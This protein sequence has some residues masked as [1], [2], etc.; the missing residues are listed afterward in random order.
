MPAR[1]PTTRR[2]ASRGRPPL[3]GVQLGF[4]GGGEGV[5]APVVVGDRLYLQSESYDLLCLRKS[6]GKLLWMRTNSY[7]DALS[8]AEKADAFKDVQPLAAKLDGLNA[9]IVA[10]TATPKQLEEKLATEREIHKEIAPTSHPRSTSG[11]T[12]P[13]WASRVTHPSPTAGSSTSGSAWAS[14]PATT[15]TAPAAGSAPTS[16]PPSST[17]SPPRPSSSTARSSSSW[18]DLIAFDAATGQLAW[19]T[20]LMPHTGFNP[21]AS[22]TAPRSPPASAARASSCSATAASCGRATARWSPR[23][24]TSATRASPRPSSR[25]VGC[26]SQRAAAWQL[27]IQ[28]LPDAI[29][30]PL[31]LATQTVGVRSRFPKY[32]MPW[33][34]SSPVIHD[35]LAYLV[36]NS[37]LTVVDI[38]G[39][40]G[41]LPEAPRPRRVPVGERGRGAGVGVSPRWRAAASTS[42]GTPAAHSSSSRAG[43]TSRWPRTRSRT[44]SPSATGAERHERFVAN[45]VADGNRLYIRGEGNLYAIGPNNSGGNIMR[46]LFIGGTGEISTACVW[47]C[48]EAGH[49]VA[50]FNRGKTDEELPA[51][52]RH[53]TGD[54]KDDAAYAGAR[55][56]AFRRRLPV[57]R[58]RLGSGPARRRGLRRPLRAIRLHLHRLGLPEAAHASRH[59]RGR[60]AGQPLL[61]LQ[62]HEGRDGG[63]P[64]ASTPTGGCP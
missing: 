29:T 55:P 62:P 59:H 15:S 53:I 51:A 16:S 39:R 12:R 43:R 64:A 2:R 50:V 41:G 6:D 9:A 30:E 63:V 26:S 19:Q 58:L 22:S 36:N 33:H 4:Y 13:T 46:V 14:P 47:R 10:G 60:A 49:D 7:F 52:V 3:P 31:K 37:V 34:L 11:A 56:G 24:P 21:G 32:Y 35:G 54:L 20:P 25:A 27:V 28:T 42:S 8:D 61:A 40:R 57:R 5:G 17:A 44:S 1:R 23:T 45:P 38:A 18:R 48:V